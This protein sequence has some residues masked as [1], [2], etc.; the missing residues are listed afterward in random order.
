[1]WPLGPW[2]SSHGGVGAT[3]GL[4]DLRGLFQPGIL[5]FPGAGSSFG[6]TRRAGDMNIASPAGAVSRCRA[7]VRRR[8]Q[9]GPPDAL[10]VPLA[11]RRLPGA[12]RARAEDRP[13]ESPHRP[14]RGVARPGRLVLP[15]YAVPACFGDGC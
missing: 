13:E 6:D 14:A 3:V 8:L 11:G 9:H 5:W 12:G 15:R 4:D 7:H 10:L 2:L 1:M